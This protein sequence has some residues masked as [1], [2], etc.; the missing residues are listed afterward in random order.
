MHKYWYL[1]VIPCLFFHL[2]G[3]IGGPA[4]SLDGAIKIALRNNPELRSFS[5]K[6]AASKGRFLSALSPPPAELSAV[7]DYVPNGQQLGNYGEKTIGISQTFEF[8]TNYVLRGSKFAKE[9]KI[10]EQE[11]DL[12][13]LSVISSVKA[14]YFSALALKSQV[15]IAG[16]NLS[17]AEDFIKKTEIRHSVG[18][19]TNLERLTAKVQYSEALNTMEIHKNHLSSAFAELRLAL[20]IG[21][22]KTE[23]YQLSDSLGFPRFNVSLSALVGDAALSNPQLTINKLRVAAQGIERSLAWSSI[24]PDINLGVFNKKVRDDATAYYGASIGI[25]LPIWFMVDQ[26]GKIKEAAANVASA[27]FDLQS[28]DNDI[29]LK[30][31]SSYN[32]FKT[33]EKQV[34]LFQNEILPQAEEIFRIAAKSYEAGDIT[35]IEFL[36]AR[37]TIINSRSNYI[38]ALLSYNLS[39]VSLEKAIGKTLRQQGE[40][41]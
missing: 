37:A 31:Q 34:L 38:N 19:A 33:E 29:F 7:N 41:Q 24:L 12:T 16:E 20:G 11:Y 26:R 6:I 39:I 2:H 3:Q 9:I 13:K 15:Q 18:E 40:Y 25:S 10:S 23:T 4:L 17:I 5:E 30:S 22:E 8:P 32:E 28:A 14:A 35:Y 1:I 36:Q 27:E 21:K